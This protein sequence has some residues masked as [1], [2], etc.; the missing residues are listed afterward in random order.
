MII[1]TEEELQ[2]SVPN[3]YKNVLLIYKEALITRSRKDIN[4][5]WTLSEP[6]GWLT[7]KYP[8]LVSTEFGKAN[9]FAFDE[10]GEFVVE[11][12]Y[13]WIP[14]KE[15]K[16]SDDYYF[17]LTI[18][19]N[20]FFDHLLS[21]YSRQLAGGNW[22]DLGKKYTADIPIPNITNP[23]NRSELKLSGVYDQ[24]VSMGKRIS[25]GDFVD[26]RELENYVKKFIYLFILSPDE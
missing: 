4:N 19:T 15:F 10:S 21:I 14:K 17:Y 5:W 22:Y 7:T 25:S 26:L 8:K 16:D 23:K 1:L 9:S 24:L 2:E 11:R 18:F 20:P 12:G 6:R 13:G 3:Y